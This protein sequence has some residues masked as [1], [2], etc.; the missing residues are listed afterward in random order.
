MS[1]IMLFREI[2]SGDAVNAGL[3]GVNLAALSPVFN[4]PHGFVVT[5][6]AY[7]SFL[8]KTGAGEKISSLL[9]ESHG[10]NTQKTANEIQKIIIETE[11]PKEISN[12]ILEAYQ[13]L[14]FNGKV[15]ADDLLK[16]RDAAFVA[17]RSSPAREHDDKGVFGLTILN[18]KG[19]KRL[20]TSV[21][22]VWAS[23][24][25]T[26]NMEAKEKHG[27]SHDEKIAIVVQQMVD[28]DKSALC[29]S[30]NPNTEDADEIYIKAVLG[31]GE[32]FTI[33]DTAFDVYVVDKKGLSIKETVIAEQ[34][35]K[36]MLDTVTGR[37]TKTLLKDAG[38]KQKLHD[39]EIRETARLTKKVSAFFD[40]EQR[41]ELAL[42][43]GSFFVLQSKKIGEKMKAT[44]PPE[45]MRIESIGT[46]EEKPEEEEKVQVIERDEEEDIEIIE[47]PPVD[48]DDE[49]L[50]LEKESEKCQAPLEKSDEEEDDHPVAEDEESKQDEEDS[51]RE[52]KEGDTRHPHD[53]YDEAEDLKDEFEKPEEKKLS[54]H[55]PFFEEKEDDE[56]GFKFE[57]D[58]DDTSI[59]S[60]FRRN[61]NE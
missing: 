42:K 50:E 53:T 41:V 49:I 38:K 60:S 54:R 7:D 28:A 34:S 61:P 22:V 1:Y 23:L 13:A 51:G 9:S 2:T 4:V 31:L 40:C 56:P 33:G 59:F 5:A 27:I 29:Y 24:F 52:E 17:V 39:T 18:I 12:A 37:T 21:K 57:E 55:E 46:E 15:T 25:L 14:S 43:D 19:E 26:K 44:P 35:K 47:N 10:E 6:E 30:L 48:Y 16:D 36:Y 11:M 32:A 45:D 20:I 8:L 58:E 3:K